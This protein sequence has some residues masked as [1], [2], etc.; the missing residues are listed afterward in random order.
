MHYQ[1]SLS[2]KVRSLGIGTA[3]YS[4]WIES[5][6]NTQWTHFTVVRFVYKDKQESLPSYLTFSITFCM[7]TAESRILL[8]PLRTGCSFNYTLKVGSV[9]KGTR[10]GWKEWK[11]LFKRKWYQQEVNSKTRNSP[12]Y[13]SMVSRVILLSTMMNASQVIPRPGNPWKRRT[14]FIHY[15]CKYCSLNYQKFHQ[16]FENT[17]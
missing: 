12:Q 9:M 3:F 8:F 5:C 11:A 13:L 6:T 4:D 15:L 1:S 14:V 2:T 17:S 16:V 7:E 10:R